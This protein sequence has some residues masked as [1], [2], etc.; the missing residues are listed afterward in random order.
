MYMRFLVILLILFST[1]AAAHSRLPAE[2]GACPIGIVAADDDQGSGDDG[3][4]PEGEGEEEE[5]D[6]E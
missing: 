1:A 6:C 2:D 5:P 3:G 4:E